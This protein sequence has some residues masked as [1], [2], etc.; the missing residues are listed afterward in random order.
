M[1]A[2]LED[3]VAWGN[4]FRVSRVQFVKDVSRVLGSTVPPTISRFASVVLVPTGVEECTPQL[5]K[6]LLKVDTAGRTRPFGKCPE[7]GKLLFVGGIPFW[8]VE[9]GWLVISKDVVPR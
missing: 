1:K 2:L 6:T 8:S 9:D 3:E 5:T 4:N 7:D